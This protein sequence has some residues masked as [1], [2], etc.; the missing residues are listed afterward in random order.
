MATI[1]NT[2]RP[3]YRSLHLW[4]ERRL[5]KRQEC[6]E[7]GTTED[8]RYHWANI[9]GE[10]KRETSDWRRLCVPCHFREKNPNQCIKGHELTPQNTL[11][12]N[13]EKGWRDCR[14]CRRMYSAKNN[15]RRKL[16]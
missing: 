9:S 3:G 13:P 6:W 10:Y 4:V 11:S 7:C 12:R 5:G 16:K 8:R 1:N 2:H 15:L 14:E